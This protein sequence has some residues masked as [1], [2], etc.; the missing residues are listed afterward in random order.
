MPAEEA[1][2]AASTDTTAATVF[3]GGTISATVTV[4]P[5]SLVIAADSGYDIARSRGV[6]V[7]VL[8]GDM[9]SISAE[10][11]AEAEELGITIERFPASKDATDL[12]IAIDAGLRLGA[13]HVTIY[14][15]EGGSLGHLL[16]IALGLTGKRWEEAHVIWK[17]GGATVY[18]ALPSCPITIHSPIGSIVTVLPIGNTTGVTTAGLQWALA[19]YDLERGTSRGLSNVAVEPVVSVSLDTGALL[20]IVEEMETV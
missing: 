7:D 14:A 6:A 5:S 9:D 11:L 10:G 12:E 16:G 8:V 13:T 3:A 18:R 4:D 2:E 17:I 15:G 20:I 1:V 19:D